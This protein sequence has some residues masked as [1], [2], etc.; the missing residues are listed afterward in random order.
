VYTTDWST[1]PRPQELDRLLLNRIEAHGHL[2]EAAPGSPE[3]EAAVAYLEEIEGLL[4][5]LRTKPL[6]LA[7]A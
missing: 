1:G 4:R 3:W 7:T 6:A 2:A 5:Q